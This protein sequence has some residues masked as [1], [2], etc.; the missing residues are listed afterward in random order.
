MRSGPSSGVPLFQ[1]LR[2]VAAATASLSLLALF[3]SIPPTPTVAAAPDLGVAAFDYAAEAR[4]LELTARA[5]RRARADA[6]AVSQLGTFAAVAVKVEPKKPAAPVKTATKKA[7]AKKPARASAK[8]KPAVAKK[9]TAKKPAP[10]QQVTASGNVAAV[11][12]YATAQVGKRYVFA[13]AGPNTFDCSG[14]VKAAYARIGINLT[15]QTNAQIRAGRAVSRSQLRP[16]DLIF[17]AK[18]GNVTHVAISLGGN[19]IVHAANSR[20]GVVRGTI[21]DSPVAYRRIVG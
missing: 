6:A 3:F 15:H 14:L 21:Y 9:P 20:T 8:T 12:A 13:T 11:V 19:A 2:R 18:D 1:H 17:W 4:D 7:A 5:A 10:Y 16:G